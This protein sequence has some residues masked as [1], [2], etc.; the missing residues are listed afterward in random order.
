MP[1]SI[2]IHGD[3][4]T[5]PGFSAP[6]KIHVGPTDGPTNVSNV[7]VVSDKIITCDLPE[8]DP[9]WPPRVGL[10]IT[11]PFG[12]GF[13]KRAFRYNP[14]PVFE[15]TSISPSSGHYSGGTS[16]VIRGHNFNTAV[17]VAWDLFG[18]LTPAVFTIDGSTQI[19]ALSPGG[20]QYAPYGIR[21]RLASGEEFAFKC[22]AIS[23]AWSYSGDPVIEVDSI[24]PDH[25]SSLG[26]Y[27]CTVKGRGFIDIG[28][29]DVSFQA[30]TSIAFTV[31]DDETATFVCPDT[32]TV[33]S[34]P[35]LSSGGSAPGD[36]LFIWFYQNG[37]SP[38]TSIQFHFDKLRVTGTTPLQTSRDGGAVITL[39]GESV[40]TITEIHIIDDNLITD[41]DVFASAVVID[42]E[43]ITFVMPAIDPDSFDTL[44]IVVVGGDPGSGWIEGDPGEALGL[45]Y[46]A[47]WQTTID[48]LPASRPAAPIA[49]VPAT[50]A[51]A[52]GTSVVIQV[53][54]ST[55]LTGASI[56]GVAIT[57][58]AIDDA[59]HVSGSTVA[60]AASP[61][62]VSVRVI[63]AAGS[64]AALANIFVYT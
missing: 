41:V 45:P 16:V 57:G 14:A 37:G 35:Y 26:G 28:L 54:N 31:V 1:T 58:F 6:S 4:F 52:G 20:T 40:D 42:G 47:N 63:S 53:A 39:V 25:G 27:T 17:Y 3:R 10:W 36:G 34:D 2:T 38:I 64:S 33:F 29:V 62:G 15:V 11:T 12:L 61:S 43:H 48:V 9:S 50:G 49:I 46:A 24:S 30:L 18:A 21:V 19:T 59:T 32:L 55:G 22:N 23:G 56:D 60:H 5:G 13:R 44:R 7:V 8:R 51:I